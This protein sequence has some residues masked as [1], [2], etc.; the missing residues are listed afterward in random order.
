MAGGLLFGL[1]AA[2][3]VVAS[4]NTGGLLGPIA[5]LAM[6]VP[7]AAV[8]LVSSR[9]WA[10][11]LIFVLLTAMVLFVLHVAGR[12]PS[13]PIGTSNLLTGRY[14]VT[15]AATII[16]T[17]IASRFANT[18]TTLAE[19]N[20]IHA[21][22]DH[23]TGLTNRRTLDLALVREVGR[24][25]KANTWL[26]VILCDVD[27][28]K[29]YND[30]NG[31]QAGDDCLVAIARELAG[32]VNRPLD[33]VGR[34]GGEE[35]LLLLPDTDANG[36]RSVVRRIRA[37]LDAAAL[38]VSASA[39]QHVTV[40]LGCVSMDGGTV[41]SIDDILRH[42]DA[43]LYAGKAAGRDCG[44]GAIIWNLRDAE[45][46]QHQTPGRWCIP[47]SPDAASPRLEPAANS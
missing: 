45:R 9:A 33:V 47:S 30:T 41:R 29:R 7:L 40:T 43:A 31:H 27:H 19:K 15:I 5:G 37:K 23:L 1:L 46:T 14:V 22:F 12:M 36:V 13:H 35:F 3:I 18:V 20:F 16:T 10:A 26:S 25:V 39:T 34:F 17:F 38:P 24:A 21:S 11:G 4:L 8:A 28:F 2:G 32:S 44:Q 6:V 42:A